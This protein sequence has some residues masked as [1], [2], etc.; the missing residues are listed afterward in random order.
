[1]TLRERRLDREKRAPV[2]RLTFGRPNR[3]PRCHKL[4]VDAWVHTLNA[5]ACH[6]YELECSMHPSAWHESLQ[7]Y[8]DEYA[9]LA[10]TETCDCEGEAATTDPGKMFT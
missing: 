7:P 10:H 1:M 4:T 5:H 9:R 6:L 2:R 3:C 8:R